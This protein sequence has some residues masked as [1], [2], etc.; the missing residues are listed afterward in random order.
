MPSF[1]A[2]NFDHLDLARGARV[3]QVGAGTGYYAALLAEMVGADGRVTAV[4]YDTGLAAR[5]RAN[6]G[7]WRQVEVVA[8]DGRTHDPGEVDAVVVFA[9]STHPAEL[10]L[11]RLAD[12]GR[13]VMP[14]TADDWR[15]FMLRAVR[16]GDDFDAAAISGVGIFPCAGGR[17]EEAAKRLRRTLQAEYLGRGSASDLP[18]RA[19]HRGEA[20]T[21]DEAKVWYFAPGFWL[22][23]ATRAEL[24]RKPPRQ[25]ALPEIGTT[26]ARP[27]G[28]RAAP[29]SKP[30]PPGSS[31]RLPPGGPAA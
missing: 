23:R 12:G 13:L 10:W 28:T 6:L 3:L 29:V 15:G 22:E 11:A 14:L 8:G 16:H 27:N 2:H 18:I 5:A 4:E 30:A 7:A 9:G 24:A 25:P 31:T 21:E 26:I 20:A 17:D 1:W 19:L